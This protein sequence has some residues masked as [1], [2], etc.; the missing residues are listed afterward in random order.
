MELLGYIH[1]IKKRLWVL[2]ATTLIFAV[3][4]TVINF[5]FFEKIYS[6]KV[7]LYVANKKQD[8]SIMTYQ[9]MMAGEFLAKDY[10]ELIKSRL[11]CEAVIDTLKLT[12]MT[13]DQLARMINIELKTET[14]FIAVK[15]ENK[16]PSKAALLAN[17]VA[18]VFRTKAVEL[19]NIENAYIVDR[20]LVPKN[21][22]KPKIKLNI[23]ISVLMGMVL[24]LAII[25]LWDYLDNTIKVPEDIQKHLHLPVLGTIPEY[26]GF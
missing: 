10:Q 1:I 4:S 17:A 26:N 19:L 15:V 3:T 6:A 20:A 11:V 14:R 25:L 22:V 8:A 16:D 9:D 18:D 23:A 13:A 5:F 21:P 24:G 7:T 12:D 2:I